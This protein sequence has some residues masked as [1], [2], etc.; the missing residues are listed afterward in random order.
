M[1]IT[2]NTK[3]IDL[4]ITGFISGGGAMRVILYVARQLPPLPPSSG[5]WA[6]LCYKLVSGLTGHDSANNATGNK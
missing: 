1:I 4:M 3:H 6:T 5:W 2:D